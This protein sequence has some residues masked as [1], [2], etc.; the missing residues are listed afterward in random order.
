[1]KFALFLLGP[2]TEPEVGA[3]SRISDKVIALLNPEILF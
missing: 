1:M 2:W 3:Q